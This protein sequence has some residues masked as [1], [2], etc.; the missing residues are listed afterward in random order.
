[1]Y[2]YITHT[3]LYFPVACLL[4][5]DVVI[6]CY[7]KRTKCHDWRMSHAKWLI[8]VDVLYV[9]SLTPQLHW[10]TTVTTT[11]TV[12]KYCHQCRLAKVQDFLAA[13]L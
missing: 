5:F 13:F 2:T 12:S 3:L 11:N 4:C 10:G 6:S 9:V 1:M 7:K 8:Q